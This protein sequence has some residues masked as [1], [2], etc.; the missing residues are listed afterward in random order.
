MMVFMGDKKDVDCHAGFQ[1]L[2]TIGQVK[3]SSVLNRD[4][5]GRPA[6]YIRGAKSHFP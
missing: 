4:R 3:A 6:Q 1:E 5:F 2:G